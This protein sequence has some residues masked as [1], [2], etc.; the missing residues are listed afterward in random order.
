MADSSR[1][2]ALSSL[3]ERFQSPPARAE[4]KK[5][6]AQ[7][8]VVPRVSR[9]Q[10]RQQKNLSLLKSDVARILRLSREDGL[11]QARLISAALDAYEAQRN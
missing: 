2:T 8:E 5:V 4:V 1:A 3:K 11:S 9:A 7:P 10:E 6:L